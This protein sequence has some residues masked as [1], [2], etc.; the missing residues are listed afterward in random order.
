MCTKG[1]ANSSCPTILSHSDNDSYTESD[2]DSR[3][4]LFDSSLNTVNVSVNTELPMDSSYDPKEEEV[5]FLHF[6]GEMEDDDFHRMMSVDDLSYSIA[7]S[8]EVFDNGEWHT[9]AG[10]ETCNV[11]KSTRHGKETL[12]K[13]VQ[14]NSAQGD[15]G[16]SN[17]TYL[18]GDDT[19][20]GT[21]HTKTDV[22]ES[23]NNVSCPERS[24]LFGMNLSCEHS[25]HNRIIQDLCPEQLKPRYQ[26]VNIGC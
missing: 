18:S 10:L 8:D 15:S 16:I 4:E 20:L 22:Y 19:R 6:Y 23:S 24:R 1:N 7:F 17:L 26:K 11:I 3:E 12:G 2:S 14:S 9:Y 21:D 13:G 25:V 5:N